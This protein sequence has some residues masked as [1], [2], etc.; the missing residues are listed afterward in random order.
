[1]LKFITQEPE[2]ITPLGIT[3]ARVDIIVDEASELTTNYNNIEFTFGSRA[4]SITDKT[5]YGLSSAGTWIDQ[6]G[7]ET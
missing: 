2:E 3:K 6:K 5:F 1:M 7:A 4:W